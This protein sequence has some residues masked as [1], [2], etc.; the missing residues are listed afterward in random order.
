MSNINVPPD[1]GTQLVGILYKNTTLNFDVCAMNVVE[2]FQH[3]C[4]SLP[5]LEDVSSDI[6]KSIKLSL[7]DENVNPDLSVLEN[8]LKELSELNDTLQCGE[9][10]FYECNESIEKSTE[11]CIQLLSSQTNANVFNQVLKNNRDRILKLFGIW[12]LTTNKKIKSNIIELF[13]MCTLTDP[14]IIKLLFENTNIALEL[15]CSIKQ[16]IELADHISLSKTCKC[17]ILLITN[18]FRMQLSF[19]DFLKTDDFLKTLFA[20][21]ESEQDYLFENL[22]EKSVDPT[23][24]K[25]TIME[26]F[27]HLLLS[28]NKKFLMPEDNVILDFIN[29]DTDTIS[30]RRFLSETIVNL[31]NLEKD[32]LQNYQPDND[33]ISNLNLND[34]SDYCVNSILKFVSDLFSSP[35]TKYTTSIFYS[36][37]FN[38]LI[39]IILRKLSNLGPDDQIR[40]D[41]LSLVQLIIE[42]SNYLESMYR[43]YDLMECFNAILGEKSQETIDQDIIRVLLKQY[44]SLKET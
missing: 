24:Q 25:Q 42:N 2:I 36:N 21:I 6:I 12:Q 16:D 14:V 34:E 9:L 28:I 1:L 15:C 32:P 13:N 11:R 4:T 33:L 38:V 35:I 27:I 20:A 3:L 7:A 26:Y 29:S 43:K 44:P 23:I 8:D 30:N 37:D 19:I 31:F 17:L 40:V 22:H 18:N 5:Q 39:D 41:Y 10:N